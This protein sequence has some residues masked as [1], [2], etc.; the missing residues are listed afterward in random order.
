MNGY[1][2]HAAGRALTARRGDVALPGGFTARMSRHPAE[3]FNA[4]GAF[5]GWVRPRALADLME[6]C[7]GQGRV[8]PVSLAQRLK[9]E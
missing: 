7:A 1:G 3:L 8:D 6:A 2:V 5:V 9:A 4:S